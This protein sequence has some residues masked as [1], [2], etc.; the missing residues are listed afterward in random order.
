MPSSA[1]SPAPPVR[2]SF[3]PRRS[4]DLGQQLPLTC[5]LE[6]VIEDQEPRWGGRHLCTSLV[7]MGSAAGPD[8]R[9]EGS[10]LSQAV[11]ELGEGPVTL[12]AG[13]LLTPPGGEMF[14]QVTLLISKYSRHDLVHN[15]PSSPT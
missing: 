12:A 8:P 5:C 10:E 7:G 15:I 2:P 14:E 11:A 9:R 13:A 6:G 4:S 3:P 1:C